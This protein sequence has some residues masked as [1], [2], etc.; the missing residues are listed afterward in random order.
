M[1]RFALVPST[2][3][4]L[5]F[6]RDV[7]RPN[8]GLTLDVGHLIMAGENPGQAVAMVGTASEPFSRLPT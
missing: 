6:L 7:D 4:A 5:L 8:F 1:S 3:A 2:G